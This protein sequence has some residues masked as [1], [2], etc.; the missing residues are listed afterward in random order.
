[1]I[2]I[3]NFLPSFFVCFLPLHTKC[4]NLTAIQDSSSSPLYVKLVLYI[5]SANIKNANKVAI[6]AFES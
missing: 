4:R 2:N 1:M 5:L 6:F 3:S